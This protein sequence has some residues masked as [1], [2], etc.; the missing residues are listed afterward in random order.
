MKAVIQISILFLSVNLF[1]QSKEQKVDFL[2][3]ELGYFNSM[4]SAFFDYHLENLKNINDKN[5][6]RITSLVNKLSDKEILARLSKAYL[7]TFTEK[8]IDELYKFYNS[9]TGK[10]Y[11][12]SQ[13]LIENNVKDN[14]KDIFQ[15]INQIEEENHEK[16]NNQAEYLT[17]FFESKFEKPNGFY[18]VTE[19]N[20]QTEDSKFEL[21][22]DPSFTPKDIEDV[23]SSYNDLGKLVIDIKF[24]KSSANKLKEITANNIN[25]GMAIII[26][27]KIITMPIIMSE[28]SDGKLQISGSYKVDEIKNIVNKLKQ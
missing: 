11:R 15:E 1:S 27:Q 12:S 18:L 9:E 23:K 22:E 10:K 28:I 26:D 20:K 13:N 3:K 14:F 5:D 24:K 16:Q 17:R 19:N 2:I 4:K 25:K 6:S 8:E 21:E 7:K